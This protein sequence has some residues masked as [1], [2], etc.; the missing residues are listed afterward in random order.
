MSVFSAA[1][2]TIFTDPNMAADAVWRTGGALPGVPVRLIRDMPDEVQAYG[3]SRVVSD[4]LIVSVRVSEVPSPKKG[5]ICQF[6][7]EIYVVQSAPRR[8]REGL[9]WSVALVPTP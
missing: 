5:D 8:D 4:T 2:D 9:V 6:D 7:G 3:V 1:I